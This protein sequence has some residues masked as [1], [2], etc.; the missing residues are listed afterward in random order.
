MIVGEGGV[1]KTALCNSMLGIPFMETAS[2]PGI[3]QLSCSVTDDELGVI[4][5]ER[6][7]EISEKEAAVAKHLG[8]FSQDSDLF[9][10]TDTKSVDDNSSS[11]KMSGKVEANNAERSEKSSVRERQPQK[12]TEGIDLC[13]L[14]SYLGDIK[15]RDCSLVL[16]LFDFGGQ[17]VFEVLH[18]LFL[19]SC[20]VYVIVFRMDRMVNP[21]EVSDAL[22]YLSYWFN[23]VVMHTLYNE[24]PSR[25]FIVGTCKDL[26]PESSSHRQ[27]SAE[28]K[29]R[30][31]KNIG[32][33]N[34]CLNLKHDLCFFPVSNKHGIEDKM[35]MSL[36][37][38]IKS[39]AEKEPY[40]MEP[41]PVSWFKA[42]DEIKNAKK[43][44]LILIVVF[45]I[46]VIVKSMKS[47]YLNFS[48]F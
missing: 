45:A 33:R 3:S 23:S 48:Y 35:I 25:I 22:S 41:R 47:M 32:W 38:Q 4:F 21:N 17:R 5:S 2:T 12:S 43:S 9:P 39:C 27:I 42:Y 26:V 37:H 8:D 18:N 20:G 46:N 10:D 36:M 14:T 31:A 1:G 16:S 34:I 44:Y 30:L 29:K 19:T 15:I 6:S 40:V 7:R 13:L 11:L 28:I 24:K